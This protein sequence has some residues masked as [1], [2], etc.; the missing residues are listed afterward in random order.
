MSYIV[1]VDIGTTNC[2]LVTVNEKGKTINSFKETLTSIQPNEG[3]Y[4]QDAELIFQTVLRLL[5]RSLSSL[6]QEEIA[7]IGFSAAMH[8]ILAI[9]KDGIPITNA[10]TWADTRSKIYARQLRN[11]ESGRNIYRQTGTPIHAMSPLC[12]LIFLKNENHQLFAQAYKFISI[13]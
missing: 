6:Q 12:K 2:K 5:R 13:K 10:I 1:A 8:S 4:E 9:D 11:T 7:C 3:C